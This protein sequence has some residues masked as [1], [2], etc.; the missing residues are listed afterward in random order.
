AGMWGRGGRADRPGRQREL[1]GES[2]KLGLIVS[3][4]VMLAVLAV[5]LVFPGKLAGGISPLLVALAALA[6]CIAVVPGMVTGYWLGQQRRDLML[7]LAA[8][9]AV[10]T[11]AAALSAP[12]AQLLAVPLPARCP[13]PFPVVP[14]PA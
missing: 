3:A 9:G 2:L 6:G 5:S 7:A 8:A 10:I 1:L 13:P 4:P 11:L 12:Q 14:P